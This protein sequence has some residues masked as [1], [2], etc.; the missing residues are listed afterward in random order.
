MLLATFD[1]E[2]AVNLVRTLTAQEGPHESVVVTAPVYAQAKKVLRQLSAELYGCK[3]QVS[4]EFDRA[5]L[6][7]WDTEVVAVP[8]SRVADLKPEV[9][10]IANICQVPRQVL[11]KILVS[12][13]ES[14]TDLIALG[15]HMEIYD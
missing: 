12:L 14:R 7:V 13:G 8:L 1:V 2:D 3:G 10:V 11:G 15:K 9:L 4:V 5:S 6:K